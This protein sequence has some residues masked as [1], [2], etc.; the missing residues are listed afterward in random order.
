MIES[1][2][3]L[4]CE[5]P[6]PVRLEHASQHLST[7]SS[8]LLHLFGS[9]VLKNSWTLVAL[10]GS[11]RVSHKHQVARVLPLDT[12][13]RYLRVHPT[14]IPCSECRHVSNELGSSW[15]QSGFVGLAF[16]TIL[17]CPLRHVIDLILR[18]ATLLI[19]DDDLT[20]L[21]VDC[22]PRSC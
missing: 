19:G 8:G 11:G 9:L 14:A 12:P 20:G 13:H 3:S 18:H 1:P 16:S 22:P 21:S 2:A 15:L 4:Q 5:G 6:P 17:L 7:A 10:S